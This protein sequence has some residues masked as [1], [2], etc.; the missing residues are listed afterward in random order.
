MANQFTESPILEEI[1][2]KISSLKKAQGKPCRD[3]SSY[4]IVPIIFRG[5]K[6]EEGDEIK[7]A[8]ID[9]RGR[10]PGIGPLLGTGGYAYVRMAYLY[11]EKNQKVETQPWAMKIVENVKPEI[12]KCIRREL[13]CLLSLNLYKVGFAEIDNTYYI[14][15]EHLGRD[16]SKAYKAGEFKSLT[17]LERAWM[18]FVS[19]CNLF[20]IHHKTPSTGPAFIHRDIKPSNFMLSRVSHPKAQ[21]KIVPDVHI[22]DFSYARENPDD[23]NVLQ[24]SKIVGTHQY[25]APEIR[26]E[27]AG[28]KS[29]IF[30]FLSVLR[31]IYGGDENTDR[32]DRLTVLN[33]E[34]KQ[35]RFSNSKTREK[36]RFSQLDSICTSPF[37][38]NDVLKNIDIPEQLQ[39]VVPLLQKV[40]SRM[41]NAENYRARPDS[42]ELLIFFTSLTNIC[43]IDQ[44]IKE[45]KIKWDDVIEQYECHRAKLILIAN[46]WWKDNKK[47]NLTYYDWLNNSGTVKTI[48]DLHQK[49]VLNKE[50]VQLITASAP[51]SPRVY[52][53]VDYFLKKSENPQYRFNMVYLFC[54]N[55]P[56]IFEAT[57]KKLTHDPLK[58]LA[59]FVNNKE[60]QTTFGEIACEA[61]KQKIINVLFSRFKGYVDQ[62][63]NEEQ[64]HGSDYYS[65][66]CFRP[67]TCSFSV[68]QKIKAYELLQDAYRKNNGVSTFFKD[69]NA[70]LRR[71]CKQ[72]KLGN[73]AQEFV[74]HLEETKKAYDE[75]MARFSTSAP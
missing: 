75:N 9:M 10:T 53:R 46:G 39:F 71:A 31:I 12:P 40:F 54:T 19:I 8:V 66:S 47:L 44:L 26:Y 17:F 28:L 16:F 60:L 59:K 56:A 73:L 6:R 62:K 20:L 63:K 15:Q 49:G 57:L 52:E 61:V 5:K 24:K 38:L 33:D 36:Y 29:D 2:A 18:S 27:K 34:L 51:N 21:E 13:D 1:Q 70:I 7:F 41:N 74:K 68:G 58:F 22:I 3:G 48:L 45:A 37:A 65:G 23:P 72:G 14:L 4:R 42:E 67:D 11:D 30:S 69:E 25:I 64:E 43:L 55:D 32:Y 50:L 35:N